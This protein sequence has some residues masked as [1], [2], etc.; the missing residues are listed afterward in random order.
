M[1][2]GKKVGGRVKGTPNKVT[3]DL[4]AMVLGALADAGGQ[5]YL[6]KQAQENATAFLTLA[7]K[8]LPKELTGPGGSALFPNRIE[9]VPV[10]PK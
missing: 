2:A 8:C 1:P 9:L 4:R 6:L 7:G 10:K 3:A 5:A